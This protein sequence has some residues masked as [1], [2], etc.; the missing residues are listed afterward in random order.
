MSTPQ[1]PPHTLVQ[2]ANVKVRHLNSQSPLGSRG[3]IPK[4]LLRG[5]RKRVMPEGQVGL[6]HVLQ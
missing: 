4:E 3:K 6:V 2:A 5:I 1:V